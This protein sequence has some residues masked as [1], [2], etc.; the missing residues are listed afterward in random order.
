MSEAGTL[1]SGRFTI[2]RRIGAG[3]MGVVYEALDRERGHAVAVKQLTGAEAL[4]RLKSEFRALADVVHPNLVRLYELIGEGDEWFFTMEL[5]DGVNFLHYLRGRATALDETTER[6]TVVDDGRPHIQVEDEVEAHERVEPGEPEAVVIDYDAVRRVVRQ[7]GEGVAALH[8]AGKLHRDLKPSN[9]LVTPAGRVVILDFGLTTDLSDQQ[10]KMTFGGTPAYMAP[11]QIAD[12]PATDASDIYAIGVMLYEVLTGTLPFSGNFYSMLM[13][14]RTTDPRPPIEIVGQIPEE[15]SKLCVELLRRDPA[16]RP[17]AREIVERLSTKK[18][19]ATT[20]TA[21]LSRPRE[22][23]F[24]GRD[25]QLA[26]L[27]EALVATERGVPVTVMLRGASGIGKT[28]LVRQFLQEVQGRDRGV[29]VFTGRCYEQESVPYKAVDSLIDDLAR[30]LKR[31][32]PLEARALLPMDIAA[33]AR[34]FPVLQE[35]DVVSRARRK[36]VEIRDSQELRRRAFSALRELI[37]RLADERRLILFLD[38]VQW[39]DRDSAALLAEVLHPPNAPAVLVIAAHRTEE[40]ESSPMLAE[41]RR[42]RDTLGDVREIALD[43]LSRS[44]ARN[45]ARALMLASPERVDAVARE[46]R[47]SP[48][49]I[50]ELARFSETAGAGAMEYAEGEQLLDSVIRARIA[51]L[52]E[53]GKTL[54]EMVAVAGRPIAASAANA[55]AGLPPEDE[56]MQARL[57]ADHLL[58]TRVRSGRDDVDTHHDRIREA[59]LSSLPPARRREHHGTLA[60]TLE[61]AGARDPELLAVHFLGA[62]DQEKS[63]HYAI[64]AGDRAA[65]A[66]AFENAAYFFQMALALQAAPSPQLLTKLADALANGGRGAD[67]APYYLR[68]AEHSEPG[69]ALELRRRAS[70]ELLRSGH[71]DEGLRII[72]GVLASVGLRLPET[73][74][75]AILGL[76]GRRLLLQLRGLRARERAADQIDPALLTKIDVL[77][78]VTTGLARIDNIRSAYFQPLHLRLALKAG[79]PY[80][81]ARAIATEACFSAAM[82]SERTHDRTERLV[83]RA[84]RRAQ[85]S[86]E[87]HAV[88]LAMMARSMESFYL[89]LFRDSLTRAEQAEAIFRERCT[90]VSWEINTTVNYALCSLMYLGALGQL[91]ERVPQRLREAE[92]RGDLYAGIDPVG[93]PGIVWLAADDPEGGRKAV[94]QVMDRWSLEGF[95][96]QHY[97]EMF[98]ENQIDLYE[99]RWASAWRRAE[100]RWP[101][102][103]AALLLRL[104]FVR[105]EALHLKG[106]SALAA[107]A[108]GKDPSLI[109]VAERDALAIEKEKATWALP[110]AWSLRAG[111]AALRGQVAESAAHLDRAAR[112][113]ERAE[114]M[115]YAK[116]ASL[117]RAQLTR[118]D[119]SPDEYWMRVQGVKRPDRLLD[120]LIPGVIPSESEG[121]GREGGTRRAPPPAQVPRSRSG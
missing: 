13:Q 120:V 19:R 118:G 24:V 114:M 23:P 92:E 49:F 26:R 36:T 85:R 4:I 108:G 95:H 102:M 63:A 88:G 65:A 8:A 3:G 58:R 73:P 62:G 45:L 107:A 111:V 47:G 90:G 115:L 99:G 39:G 30:H 48:F 2:Q 119:G 87:P 22:S 33:L 5:V 76:L 7:L 116:A 103:K 112:A 29:V 100:E 27:E 40:A 56:A 91:A 57:R 32:S 117:R 17:T 79:E 54:L 60:R 28:A 25:E 53:A 113:F 74:R 64:E 70:E 75:R 84:E 78:G 20:T 59:V 55:A 46:S 96:F 110:L 34:L 6:S 121:P 81:V 104:P 18:E 38:D 14:K 82:Q 50:V 101:R 89:G 31:V 9:V 68:A 97:L 44:E 77:W 80:R 61:A 71:V 43:E 15:L 10:R 66:L 105:V 106:R 1:A 94:R 37:A 86:G 11:E 35:L 67:A 41:L 109:E 72:R 98:A 93:R 16:K 12:L 52:P 51:L 21:T 69:V 42:L 83:S